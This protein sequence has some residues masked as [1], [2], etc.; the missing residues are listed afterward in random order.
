MRK[1]QT[2]SREVVA[3]HRHRRQ[4]WRT[5][6]DSSADLNDAKAENVKAMFEFTKEHG[7]Y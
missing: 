2:T 5:Y 6:V 1:K 3:R 4:R 7:V